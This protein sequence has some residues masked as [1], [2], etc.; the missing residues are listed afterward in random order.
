MGKIKIEIDAKTDDSTGPTKITG[1]IVKIKTG[2]FGKREFPCG[3]DD[4]NEA[5][6]RVLAK[7]EKEFNLV[8]F[9]KQ[10]EKTIKKEEYL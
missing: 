7:I 1:F 3:P 2:R 4:L 5:M 10:L 6:Y 9:L 8:D